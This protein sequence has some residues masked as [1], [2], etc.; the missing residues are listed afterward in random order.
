MSSSR[1]KQ[2]HSSCGPRTTP[3]TPG[4]RCMPISR[5]CFR[6]RSNF[7]SRPR[8]R[9]RPHF[10]ACSC[11][12]NMWAKDNAFPSWPKVHARSRSCAR[13]QFCSCPSLSSRSLLVLVP[14]SCWPWTTPSTP[15]RS[16]F[17]PYGHPCTM[18]N[19]F[20]SH[21]CTCPSPDLVPIPVPVPLPC[22][23]VPTSCGQGVL[24]AQGACTH[25]SPTRTHELPRARTL[26]GTHARAHART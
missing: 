21:L 15:G 1:Y 16:R 6:S 9:P 25:A 18:A 20:R 7:G 22:A 26:V 5:S 14:S 2:R 19:R 17:V 23:S 10:R 12:L 24:L 4:P 13:A 8:P 3:S 11:S